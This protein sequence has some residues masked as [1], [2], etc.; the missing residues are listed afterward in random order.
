MASQKEKIKMTQELTQEKVNE[1]FTEIKQEWERSVYESGE[2]EQMFIALDKTGYVSSF[3]FSYQQVKEYVESC[4][5]EMPALVE[6]LKVN[7]G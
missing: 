4:G 5:L 7:I 6:G 3:M 2:T 1:I